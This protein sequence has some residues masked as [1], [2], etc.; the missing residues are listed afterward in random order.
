MFYVLVLYK[1]RKTVFEHIAKH[2]EETVLIPQTDFGE[3]LPQEEA[4]HS[5]FAI[6][7]CDPTREYRWWRGPSIWGHLRGSIWVQC[8]STH[9]LGLH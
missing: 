7:S 3:I 9:F 8:N 2:R 1:T 5:I 4:P 6:S